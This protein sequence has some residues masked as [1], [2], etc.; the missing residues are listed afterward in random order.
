M[1]DLSELCEHLYAYIYSM[2]YI[3]WIWISHAYNHPKV[4]RGSQAKQAHCEP[5][6]Q[7]EMVDVMAT[8]VDVNLSWHVIP[9][10]GHMMGKSVQN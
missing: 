4:E 5:T 1:V 7:I 3:Y 10:M 2:I 6:R 8:G 9:E